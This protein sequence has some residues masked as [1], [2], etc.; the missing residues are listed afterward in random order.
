MKKN[1]ARSAGSQ[2]VSLHIPVASLEETGLR[3]VPWKWL[4]RRWLNKLK[5]TEGS[6]AT[7]LYSWEAAYFVGLP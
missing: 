4:E 2:T 7:N 3:K 6:E 1:S 5:P